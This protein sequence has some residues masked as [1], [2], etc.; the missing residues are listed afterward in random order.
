MFNQHEKEGK[1]FLCQIWKQN[2]VL[3]HDEERRSRLSRIDEVFDT[4]VPAM[5][6]TMISNEFVIKLINLHKSHVQTKLKLCQ[7]QQKRLSS[8]E[9]LNLEDGRE[10]N[11]SLNVGDN[12]N[13]ILCKDDLLE[14]MNALKTSFAMFASQEDMFNT[15]SEDDQTELLNRNGL[16]FVMVSL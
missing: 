16:M 7:E 2:K 5:R 3:W 4:F 12:S 6:K 9:S 14:H 13:K 15:I 10:Y 11:N 1:Q 8:E